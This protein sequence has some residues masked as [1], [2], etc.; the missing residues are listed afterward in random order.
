MY[1]LGNFNIF[2]ELKVAGISRVFNWIFHWIKNYLSGLAIHQH[3]L[4]IT[5]VEVRITHAKAG[6]KIRVFNVI[7]DATNINDLAFI[8]RLEVL[9][10]PI[11]A[12]KPLFLTI[13]L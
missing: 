11:L 7:I 10:I 6:D 12:I 8:E 5:G 13:T 3:V 2:F 4:E 1:K 9:N